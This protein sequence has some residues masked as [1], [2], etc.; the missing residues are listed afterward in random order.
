MADIESVYHKK[1]SASPKE[2]LE[3]C[4]GFVEDLASEIGL[5]GSAFPSEKHLASWAGICSGNYESAGKKKRKN[6]SR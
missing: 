2:L 6:H 1:M 5:D 3:A 4:T